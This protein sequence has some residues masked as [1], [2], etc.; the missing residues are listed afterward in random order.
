L[1]AVFGAVPP[2]PD[3]TPANDV[4]RLQAAGLEIVD[5]QDRQGDLR[6]TDVGAIVYYLKVIPWLVPDFTVERYQQQLFGLQARLDM[7][8]PLVFEAH[9]YLIEA[10]KPATGGAGASTLH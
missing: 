8:E 10:R 1:L 2:W 3:S 6:F 4:K 5:I 9:T 7:G